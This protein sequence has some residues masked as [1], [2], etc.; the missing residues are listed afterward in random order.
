MELPRFILLVE[1]ENADSLLIQRAL[2]KSALDFKMVRVKH[3]EDAIAYLSGSAPYDDRVKHPFPSVMLLDIKLPRQNGFEVLEWVRSQPAGVGRM[4]VVMLT[5]SRHAVDVNRAYDLRA[6][7]YLT[8]PETARELQEM[9]GD[10]KKYWMR[11]NE[12]PEIRGEADRR[13]HTLL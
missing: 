2:E 7:G 1:D 13:P 9:L 12:L 6:N 5:S 4:P 11:W 8:K 3:G 10:F